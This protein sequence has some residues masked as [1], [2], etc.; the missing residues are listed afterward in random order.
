MV[1]V[2]LLVVQPIPRT[3]MFPF[4]VHWKEASVKVSTATSQTWTHALEY[5][6]Y[7]AKLS[8]LDMDI[9]ARSHLSVLCTTVIES[10]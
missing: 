10:L 1:L 2:R 3:S 9:T 6:I 7:A 4:V 8:S 5:D